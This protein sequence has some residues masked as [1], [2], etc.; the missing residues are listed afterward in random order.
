M[1]RSWLPFQ[2][3]SEPETKQ[4]ARSSLTDRL[5][6]KPD[7]TSS[8][9]R[10]QSSN[11]ESYGEVRSDALSFRNMHEYGT[12]LTKYLEARK[13]IFLDDLGWHVAEVDGM[14]FDQYDNPQAQWIILHRFG[15]VLG[16]VR[17]L[18]TT[19]KCGIYSYM[20]RDAQN[21]LLGGM[22]TDILFFEAPVE[23]NVWE[24]TRFF[25]VNSVPAAQRLEVQKRLFNS[26]ALAAS[27]HGAVHVLG[28][29]PAVW[30]R[31]SRRLGVKATPI[32][33]KFT[34]D[35]FASQSVLFKVGDF[36]D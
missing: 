14:E 31:W 5:R 6:S 7:A 8:R 12:L 30:A 20:L 1:N 33:A 26:M 21:G 4:R 27:E 29:V 23:H 16:G 35:N 13:N 11:I 10:T 32:G 22:P 9:K 34:V 18:P 19:A 36:Q 28:I 25:I 17:M 3:S 2:V 24:A 15:E